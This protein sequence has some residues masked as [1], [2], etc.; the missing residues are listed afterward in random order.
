MTPKHTQLHAAFI[1]MEWKLL[2]L[3]AKRLTSGSLWLESA[4]RKNAKLESRDER[5]DVNVVFPTECRLAR[6]NCSSWFVCNLRSAGEQLPAMPDGH[7]QNPVVSSINLEKSPWKTVRKGRAL[8]NIFAG[9]RWIRYLCNLTFFPCQLVNESLGLSTGVKD[10]ANCASWHYGK[11]WGLCV[12][13][14]FSNCGRTGCAC[15]TFI[16]IHDNLHFLP[17][18]LTNSTANLAQQRHSL[19]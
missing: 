8:K 14:L 10:K 3:N 11:S 12:C 7:F 6:V 18:C 5:I 2:F 17:A 13:V 16:L 9:N 4:L 1:S 19:L 15:C